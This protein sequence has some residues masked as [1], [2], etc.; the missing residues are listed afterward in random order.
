MN[1]AIGYLRVSTREQGDSGLGLEAQRNAIIA[2]C[3]REGLFLE[4]WYSE[5]ESGKRIS[6]TLDERPQLQVAIAEARA[7]GC[8]VIVSKLDRLSRD[9][10]FISGLMVQK[11]PFIV[12]ELG[13]NTDPFMLHLFAALAE[14]E[15]K[16]I[17]DR[18]KAALGVLK[19]RG[20]ALGAADPRVRG[21]GNAAQI[22]RAAQF[23]EGTRLVIEAATQNGYPMHLEIRS[24]REQGQWLNQQGYRTI[25][26]T[27]WTAAAV[28]RIYKQTETHAPEVGTAEVESR[29]MALRRR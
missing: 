18:T 17:S 12:C 28:S 29:P 8:P 19:E 15:R 9:V 10:Y 7:L 16:L 1:K 4:S 14:K 5:V 25:R 23:A 21:K 22:K 3:E 24:L 2:F 6:D 20:V 27:V 11:V 13:M 26:G